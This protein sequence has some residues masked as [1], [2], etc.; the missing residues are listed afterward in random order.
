MSSLMSAS[1][2]TMRISAAMIV[3]SYAVPVVEISRRIVEHDAALMLFHDTLD[4]REAEAGSLNPRRHIGLGQPVPVLLGQAD[5]IVGDADE[6]CVIVEARFDD[7]PAL[8]RLIVM[9]ARFY[10]FTRVL[11]QIGDGLGD[12]P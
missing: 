5:A 4:D 6:R 8:R 1:S 11:D 7:D 3:S 2:S 10:R 9:L 12:Q